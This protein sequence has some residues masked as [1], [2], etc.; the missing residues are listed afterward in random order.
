MSTIVKIDPKPYRIGFAGPPASFGPAPLLQWIAIAD[1]GVDQT[2]QRKILERGARNVRRIAEAFDWSK[3]GAVIVSPVEGGA[4][5]IIDG[6]HRTTAAALAGIKEVPC[7]VVQADRA[8][9]ADAFAAINGMVTAITPLQLHAAR[10]AAGESDAMALTE[11]LAAA[12]VKVCRYPIPAKM[13]KPGETLA[14]GVLKKLFD[15][16][17]RDVLV[18]ALRCITRTRKGWPGMVRA[19]VVSA[20]CGVLDGEPEWA[21]DE[22]RLLRAM[23]RLDFEAAFASAHTA[24]RQ[25]GTSLAVAL[26]TIFTEHLE[27]TLEQV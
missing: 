16:F 17:G 13:M 26:V 8:R 18:M 22:T 7:Q 11:A 5:A 12:D 20:L 25:E 3:F 15:Q 1:L 23:Q 14:I 27:H 24:A 2:Y 6:Q 10:L 4:F 21:G 19:P 9:Q